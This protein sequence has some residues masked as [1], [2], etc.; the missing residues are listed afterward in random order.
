M[1]FACALSTHEE[2]GGLVR[3]LEAPVLA[4]LDS[5]PDLAV[6]FLQGS[7]ADVAEDLVALLRE[8]LSPKVLLG[9]T[10]E[11]VIGGGREI[12]RKPAVALL[13]HREGAD[14]YFTLLVQP[15]GE[16]EALEAAPKEIVLVLDTSGSMSGIPLEASKR[17]VARA[18]R[19]LGPRDTFNLVRFAGDN[20][21]YSKT[22]LPGTPAEVERGQGVVD[23][24]G[25]VGHPG[26]LE[27]LAEADHAGI[28]HGGARG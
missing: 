11:S 20:E 18:L 5:E 7:L 4:E 3:E 6:V 25:D 15:K 13:A 19:E 21:V 16:I 8:S 12:E 24:L 9:V 22:T 28:R 2:V 14:G 27:V 1:R 26:P 10:C 17:F 23:G